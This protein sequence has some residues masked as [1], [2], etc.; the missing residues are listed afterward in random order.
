MTK[1]YFCK[2]CNIEFENHRQL[3]GH[4]TCHRISPEKSVYISNPK[5][6]KECDDVISWKSYSTKHSTEFCSVRCRAKY[7]YKE[8]MKKI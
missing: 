6:C 5:L 1:K 3:N 7:F 4:N 8:N 2:K